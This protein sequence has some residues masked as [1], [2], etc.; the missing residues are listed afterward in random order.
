MSVIACA[1]KERLV[2][3]R[4][5]LVREQRADGRQDRRDHRDARGEHVAMPGLVLDGAL[6]RAV[7]VDLGAGHRILLR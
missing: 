2:L 7:D 5:R 1:H 6:V 4:T 3:R